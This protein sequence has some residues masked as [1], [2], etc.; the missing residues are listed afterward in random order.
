M[1]TTLKVLDLENNNLASQQQAKEELQQVAESLSENKTLLSLNIANNDIDH[2]IGN[3]FVQHTAVNKTLICFEFGMNE[4]L[5]QQIIDIQKN[6]TRNK[7]AYDA[8][9]L[10]EWKERKRMADEEELMRVKNTQD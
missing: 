4:F 7:A 10:K 3:H 5:H 6:I 1:N 8:E 2:I 9:R